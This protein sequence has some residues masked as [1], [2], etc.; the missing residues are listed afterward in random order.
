MVKNE[1]ITKDFKWKKLAAS[2]IEIPAFVCLDNS[3]YNLLKNSEAV[4][5]YDT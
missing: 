2:F 1:C 4:I 3:F 5:F